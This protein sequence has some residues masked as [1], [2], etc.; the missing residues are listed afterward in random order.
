MGTQKQHIVVTPTKSIGVS[1]VLTF[2]F[3]SFGM[4]YST[5]IGAIIMIIIELIVGIV[6]FGIGLFVTHIICMV[7]GALAAHNYNQRLLRGTNTYT[8]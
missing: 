5:I 2:L 7:W 3:G 4:L 1:L 8:S 6:T